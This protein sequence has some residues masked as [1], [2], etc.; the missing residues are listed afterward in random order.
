MRVQLFHDVEHGGVGEV[1]SGHPAR[2]QWERGDRNDRHAYVG[3]HD[4]HR[5]TP[6]QPPQGAAPDLDLARQARRPT[7]HR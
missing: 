2:C 6:D 4:R 7:P 3:D 5:A 1:V